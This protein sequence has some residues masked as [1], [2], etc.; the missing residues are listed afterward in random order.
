VTGEPLSVTHHAAAASEETRPQA[1]AAGDGGSAAGAVRPVFHYDLG[2]PESYLAAERV[3]QLLPVAPEW[4]PVLAGGLGGAPGAAGVPHAAA[5]DRAAIEALAA[6]RHVQ[7]L[8]WPAGW[9]CEVRRAMV[10]ATYA[11]QIGRAVAFSLAAFRQAFAGGRDLADD[12]TI[13]IAAAACEMHPNAVLKALERDAL[14]AALDAATAEAAAA[15]VRRLP[16]LRVGDTV[17]HGD[18]GLDAA[19]DALA[20]TLT[21]PGG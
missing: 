19:V 14:G 1:V 15:G 5:P 13:L 6:Q 4:T 9:P 2:D 16:A 20:A 7:P 11:K 10:V 21:S 17:F 12:D 8:R 18:A 3:M